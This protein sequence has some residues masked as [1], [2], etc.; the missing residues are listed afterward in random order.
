MVETFLSSPEKNFGPQQ[1]WFEQ[2]SLYLPVNIFFVWH[3][4]ISS[5]WER[6]QFE[7]VS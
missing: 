4:V 7:V 6:F 3:A 2:V 1:F 5:V